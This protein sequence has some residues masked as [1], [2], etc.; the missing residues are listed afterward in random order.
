MTS[1]SG[2]TLQI[3]FLSFV[4]AE[5][6]VCKKNTAAAMVRDVG[7]EPARNNSVPS[8]ESRDTDF[9]SGGSEELCSTIWKTV[10]D[11]FS[12]SLRSW[13]DDPDVNTLAW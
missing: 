4:S 1:L 11:R 5:G 13:A 6:C 12:F 3:S 8:C 2:M 9:S 10:P 7:P